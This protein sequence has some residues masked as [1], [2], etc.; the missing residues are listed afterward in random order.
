MENDIDKSEN[1]RIV[2][3][4]QDRIKAMLTPYGFRGPRGQYHLNLSTGILMVSY[5]SSKYTKTEFTLNIGFGLHALYADYEYPKQAKIYRV[6]NCHYVNDIGW[7]NHYIAPDPVVYR[8]GRKV[9]ATRGIYWRIGPKYSHEHREKALEEI[10]YLLCDVTLPIIL[11][12][13]DIEVFREHIK[14]DDD[15]KIEDSYFAWI[16]HA[17]KSKVYIQPPIIRPLG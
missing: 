17:L 14:P 16:Y 1:E 12:W 10:E 4:L 9:K 15:V 2:A 8:M 13:N 5:K 3:Q 11:P 7:F 6:S